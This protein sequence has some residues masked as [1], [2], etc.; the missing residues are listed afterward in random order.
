[1]PT[2]GFDT[3]FGKPKKSPWDITPGLP[4]PAVPVVQS[5]ALSTPPAP[6]VGVAPAVVP[7]TTVNT[8]PTIGNTGVTGQGL[9]TVPQPVRAPMQP[10]L[11][12]RNIGNQGHEV[13]AG[14]S[15][16]GPANAVS[17]IYPQYPS[18]LNPQTAPGVSYVNGKWQ[19]VPSGADVTYYAPTNTY[20]YHGQP[21][22]QQQFEAL[23]DFGP[24]GIGQTRASNYL[25]P[26][27]VERNLTT[28]GFGQQPARYETPRI[29]PTPGITAGRINTAGTTVAPPGTIQAP[30]VEAAQGGFQDFD[31]LERSIYESQFNPVN[32]ELERQR[33]MADERL[34]ANLAQAGIAESGTGVGQRV[35]LSDEYYR[36][37][38][39][40]SEDAASRAAQT[41]YGMEYDQ[42]MKNA[43][44][45]QQANL[46]NAGFDMQAQVSNAQNLLTTNITN[47]QIAAQMGTA[48]AQ[49]DTQASIAG[50]ELGQQR[51]IAQAQMY[52][53]T[54]GLNFQQANAAQRN[55][56]DLLGLQQADLQHLDAQQTE[57][58]SM[59][60][61]TYL[62]EFALLINAGQQSTGKGDTSSESDSISVALE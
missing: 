45:R 61:N 62:K 44:L 2:L 7:T 30:V 18:G 39:A 33:G 5:A 46:A 41:R 16:T 31:K 49:L 25:D 53:S 11:L 36:K 34:A 50:A 38:I 1:M 42:S 13:A 57:V 3:T 20:Y 6:S 14:A 21:L 26:E 51:E 37:Q 32:R 59:F 60:F 58:L 54:M 29:G 17:A 9:G 28:L 23:R 52:L 48:Q 15:G 22:T 40:A 55:Y 8:T 19:E 35:E 24:Q 10:P 56:L 47:A 43:E 4:A 27:D 12:P